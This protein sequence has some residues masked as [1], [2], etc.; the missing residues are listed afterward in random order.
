VIIGTA[1]H[2]DHG[3]SALVEALTGTRMDPLP[4]ERRRGVTVDLHFAALPIPGLGK[5]GVVDV[6]GHEDLVRTMVAGATGIDLVL[7]VIAADEGIMPQTREHLAVVEQLR[8]RRGIPV[9]TKADLVESA[10]LSLVTE[11]VSKWLRNS[12]VA[13]AN[14]IATSVASGRGIAELRV[15][16]GRVLSEAPTTRVPDD[17]ARLP[18]DRAFSLAGVGTVAT[19]TAWSGR[20]RLGDTVT[21]LPVGQSG[22]IRSL[23]RHG[24]PVEVSSPG[25]RLAVGLAGIAREG[26]GRGQVLVCASDPWEATSVVDA[27]I[28]LLSSAP[29]PLTHHTR[30][31]V[32]LGTLEVMARVNHKEPIAPAAS[33]FVRLVLEEPTVARG[34]DRLILRSYSPVRV[35]GG[36]EVVDPLPPPGRPEWPPGLDS[37]NASA[38]FSALL[39]RRHNGIFERQLPV[40]LGVPPTEVPAA[41]I[42]AQVARVGPILV[43]SRDVLGAQEVAVAAVRAYQER[44]PAEPGMPTEALRQALRRAGPAGTAAIERLLAAGSFV[45]REGGVVHEAGF[46]PRVAGGDAMVDRLVNLIAA[47]A[48]APPTVSEI[49]STLRVQGVAEALRLAARGGRVIQIERDRFFGSEA[50]AGFTAALVRV[51]AA[52]PI[53]PA[54]VR[55]ETGVTRKFLIPLLEWA[56]RSALTIRRGDARVP[57]PALPT[58]R[59]G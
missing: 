3:K 13:F 51:A 49:E 53:T 56:D 58:G 20:F 48:L 12:P 16:I 4:E 57:G 35:I 33:G 59:P 9:I 24:E 52:G 54:A 22:R 6:P 21:V 40:L 14:P 27:R 29:R 5:A 45:A 55:D 50:L 36:G 23:E 28:A 37:P 43:S 15:E 18:I 25:E 41:L 8:I 19:G 46:L 44:H 10:W 39:A 31:R 30:I 2:I 47:A 7:L 17:L 11:E 38:R 32:H 26:L 1:G 34:G 42:G